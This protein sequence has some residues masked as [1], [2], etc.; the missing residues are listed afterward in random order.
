MES[1]FRNEGCDR[2]QIF[3][4]DT[5]MKDEMNIVKLGGSSGVSSAASAGV[6]LRVG[7][8]CTLLLPFGQNWRAAWVP[9]QVDIKRVG[10]ILVAER[11]DRADGRS[12]DGAHRKS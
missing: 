10:R 3:D 11:D 7:H 2:K 1:G 9:R 12:S 5:C 4:E 8:L 6:G